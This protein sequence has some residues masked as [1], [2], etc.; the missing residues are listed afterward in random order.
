MYPTSPARTSAS[1]NG[2]ETCVKNIAKT[3]S[4]QQQKP[5]SQVKGLLQYWYLL[6]EESHKCQHNWQVRDIT[7]ECNTAPWLR[8]CA[9]KGPFSPCS[10]PL[11]ALFSNYP[12]LTQGRWGWP[13]IYSRACHHLVIL[14]RPWEVLPWFSLLWIKST[15]CFP[16]SLPALSMQASV[17]V[18][19]SSRVARVRVEYYGCGELRWIK[20][21]PKGTHKHQKIC[22]FVGG[23]RGAVVVIDFIRDDV[24][25]AQLV[26]AQDCQFRGRWFESGKN[27]I[28]RKVK[29]TC[30]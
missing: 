8:T 11:F 19:S 10:L 30:I 1:T 15:K 22:G 28:N 2:R 23:R 24:K 20:M 4:A 16:P 14:M 5:E 13:F 27:S 25:L 3:F 6:H 29:S 21:R 17:A 7:I 9:L 18:V 26:R 12:L